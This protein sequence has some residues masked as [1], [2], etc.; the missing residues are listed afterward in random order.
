[1]ERAL[2]QL[3]WDRASGRCEY[4]QMPQEFD[5]LDLPID[6][7]THCQPRGPTQSGTYALPVSV[8]W[9]DIVPP[10]VRGID[11]RS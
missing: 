2:E 7:V 9:A 10:F 3:V 6:M 1:M 8:E 4:C 11:P 5:E